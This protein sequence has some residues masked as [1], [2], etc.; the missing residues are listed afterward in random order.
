MQIRLQRDQQ[1]LGFADFFHSH[2]THVGVVVLEQRLRAFKIALYAEQLFIAGHYR[3]QFG[4]LLG[5]RAEFGLI[6]NDFGV[7]EQRGQFL[8][9]VLENVQLVE[10]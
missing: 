2:F 4:I 8:E 10:Q 9:T 6:G 1:L 7:A 5:I 3:L